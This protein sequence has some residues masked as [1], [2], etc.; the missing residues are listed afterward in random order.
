MLVKWGPRVTCSIIT[1][2]TGPEALGD[3]FIKID[4]FIAVHS[5]VWGPWSPWSPCSVTCGTGVR[6]RVR[7]CT[8]LAVPYVSVPPEMCGD[9]PIGN[10]MEDACFNQHCLDGE[11]LVTRGNLVSWWRHQMETFPRYWPFVSPVNSPHKGQWRR[12]LVFSLICASI[13]NGEANDLRRHRTHY[14]VTQWRHNGRDGV[15]NDQPHAYI[16]VT[17]MCYMVS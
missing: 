1:W 12:A 8:D 14:D 3:L 4:N 11:W 2:V 9:V 17:V 6:V 16:T 15:S 5:Y 7:V 10:E 13:N